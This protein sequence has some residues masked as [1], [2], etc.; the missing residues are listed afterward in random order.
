ML[1]AR[2]SISVCLANIILKEKSY[3]GVPATRSIILLVLYMKTSSNFRHI[4]FLQYFLLSVLWF[5]VLHLCLSSILSYFC[6][7]VRCESRLIFGMQMS[8]CP[9]T[10]FSKGSPF[11]P[12]L[13]L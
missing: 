7:G 5:P 2:S 9:S 3:L 11:F 8:K 4:N 1:M 12:E 13:I 6:K 10:I